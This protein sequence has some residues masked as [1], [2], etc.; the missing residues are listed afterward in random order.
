MR[1]AVFCGVLLS[2]CAATQAA[3]T[4]TLPLSGTGADGEKPVYWDFR[5]DAGRGQIAQKWT[6]IVVPSCWEQ[7]GFGSYYYGTQG[8]G[9]PDTD[10]V[11][12]KETGTYRR[13]FEVPASWKDRAIHLV[14]EGA[15]TDTSVTI[16][17]RSAGPT[18]QGGFYR[19][20]YDITALV[21]PG[22]NDIEVSVSKESANASVN[23]AERRGDYWTFGGIFR[24]VWLEAR[25]AWHIERVAID[26]RADGSLLARVYL[27]GAPGST[28]P[29][30]S[31]RIQLLDAA[32]KPFGTPL[33]SPA[34]GRE[35]A[36]TGRFESPATWSAE[37]PRLYTA[38]VSLL[39]NGRELH[40]RSERIGFRTI[41]VRPNDGVY[42]NGRRIVLKG[43]NRHSFRPATGRTLTRSENYADA[44]L[45]RGANMNAVRMSHYPP[46]PAFLEAADE[47][48]LY[49]LDELA[50]WQGYYDTPTGARLIGQIVRRDENHPSI[51][52]WDNG[53]EGGWNRENDS[54]FDRW[55]VQRRPVLHPWAIHSGINTDHYEN[56][57]STVKLSAGPEIFMPTEFLHGLYDGGIGAG[58]RDYW[59]VMG[60]SPTVAG[61]FFWAFA[62]EGIERT[63]RDRRIDNVG[64][65]AP[66]GIVGAHHEKEGSYFA[67]RQIWSPVQVSGLSF[68]PGKLSLRI[69]NEY[70][71][72]DLADLT[73]EWRMLRMPRPDAP[74][75]AKQLGAGVVRAPRVAA[76]ETRD[77]EIRLPVAS[78]TTDDVV[79]LTA[80]GP[81]REPIASWTLRGSAQPPR[82]ADLVLSRPPSRAGNVV[83]SGA[84]SLEF[85]AATGALAHVTKD[86]HTF[87]LRG[88][89]LAAWQR[90]PGKRT[91]SAAA[92]T[93][94]LTSLELLPA[95]GELLARARYDGALR[96]VTWQRHDDEIVVQ[97][98][99]AYE[100]AA[101]ILGVQFDFPE[102]DV[103]GK[104]WVGEGPYRIWK[105]R[106]A[107]T[108]FG[109]HATDYSRS[110]PGET[111]HYPEFEGFFGAWSWLE[112]RTRGGKVLF[113]NTGDVPY[114]GLYRPSPVAQPVLDLPDLGWSFLHAVPP[115]GTKFALADVLGPQSQ[116]ATFA[117]TL[118]GTIAL[119]LVPR[120]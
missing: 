74:G 77:W 47:L 22:R 48:G 7:Q 15:M 8:R 41:E 69:A 101:D 70:D 92:G 35:V 63:D 73:F 27:D 17:G 45:I 6:R 13:T 11:I 67:V 20:S 95:G 24:P 76:R 49:V 106:E 66:D 25:P 83:V 37:T 56:Y 80:I 90:E 79:E 118:S 46:D 4:L 103:T 2:A 26:A 115:I 32:G 119:R 120:E 62:D 91:F 31:V 60:R 114:F 113:R 59:D 111:Y 34:T 71:F 81:G 18:H 104:R 50:G 112:M 3:D 29:G 94:G 12:P 108:V 39:A 86:G 28:A 109:L 96:E 117:G 65:A 54:E 36:V 97:Y 82:A 33:E 68:A 105:N 52:F 72:I 88:P 100:G 30:A 40:R 107:G 55:D 89:R 116:P 44:R 51:L 99:I 93:P 16:N 5:L 78:L 1:T 75:G 19:F 10:P 9:K 57:D 14:F 23:H 85:D 38:R 98:A 102:G 110:I 58:L 42:L 43:I 61:G 64:N 21:K 53:N 84:Y 87:D